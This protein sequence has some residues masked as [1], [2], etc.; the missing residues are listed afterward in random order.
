M[1][2]P[3]FIEKQRKYKANCCLISENCVEIIFLFILFPVRIILVNRKENKGRKIPWGNFLYRIAFN[4]F[5][6]EKFILD[7]STFF[8]PYS[9]QP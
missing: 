2:F 1:I 3:L 5:N 8:C 9:R 6:Q 4:C 7:G